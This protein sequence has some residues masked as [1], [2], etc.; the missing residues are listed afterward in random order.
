MAR[1]AITPVALVADDGVAMATAESAT[2][3]DQANGMVIDL[4]GIQAEKLVLRVTNTA[5]AQH[6]VIIRAAASVAP[7]S[8]RASLGDKTIQ[9]AAS[10]GVEWITIQD[11][12]R[13]TQSDSTLHIDF[14]ASFAGKI[15]A[16]RLP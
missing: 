7:P 4:T 15:L 1:T 9:V 6:G 12:A 3:V 5:G 13:F 2:A 16:V 8:W 10:T 11:S 14:E